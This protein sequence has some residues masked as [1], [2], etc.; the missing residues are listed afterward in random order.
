M[1]PGLR[2]TGKAEESFQPDWKRMSNPI[3]RRTDYI[4]ILILYF[5]LDN[6]I[7]LY[8]YIVFYIRRPRL[9]ECPGGA[10]PGI[11]KVAT[12]E[13]LCIIG[14]ARPKREAAFPHFTRFY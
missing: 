6:N 11:P 5:K 14:R 1:T 2:K 8:I 13:V 7:L 9:S 12:W 3:S 10:A 4:Y